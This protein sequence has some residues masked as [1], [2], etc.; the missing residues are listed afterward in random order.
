MSPT[1]LLPAGAREPSWHRATLRTVDDVRLSAHVL[2]PGAPPAGAVVL[3]HGFTA[4]GAHPSVVAQAE[5]LAAAG[6]TVVT[7]DLR[8]HGESAGV[9]TVGDEERH[10]VAA[11]VGIA[12]ESHSRIVVVGASMGAIAT[13]RYAATAEEVDGIEGVVAVSGPAG[14]ATPRTAIGLLNLVLIRTRPGRRVLARRTNV[15]VADRVAGSEP[16][17]ELVGRLQVP[18]AIVH[19]TADRV[20]PP[21]AAHVLYA[22]AREP[23]RLVI[24][25]GMGHAFHPAAQQPVLEA[26]EWARGGGGPR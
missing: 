17:T 16:P 9:C 10:D 21:S 7:F 19:G 13:L 1:P 4:G 12:R 11:A 26:V 25:E 8:G 22:A 20:I 6:F 15:R 24:V 5:V 14:W 3:V 23:R 2:E 18:V